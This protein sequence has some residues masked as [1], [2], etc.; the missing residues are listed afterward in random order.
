MPIKAAMGTVKAGPPRLFDCRNG[1]AGASRRGATKLPL[2]MLNSPT[3][4]C[5]GNPSIS[6]GGTIKKLIASTADYSF[7]R[8]RR[9]VAELAHQSLGG[10]SE[11]LQPRQTKKAA[12]AFDGVNETENI[13]E[14]LGVVGILL[15]T[16]KLDVD[17]VETFVGLGDKFPQQV[18]HKKRLRRR[19]FPSEA[20]PVCR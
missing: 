10:V 12:S 5:R 17:H 16:H 20:R 14:D 11:G 13:I 9:A 1:A 4:P 8:G 2:C 6:K 7:T 19:A 18:V 3:R 15:E